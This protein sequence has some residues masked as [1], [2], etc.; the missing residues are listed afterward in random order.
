MTEKQ[1][2]MAV[3]GKSVRAEIRHFQMPD[4]LGGKLRVWRFLIARRFIQVSILVLFMGTLHYGWTLFNQLVLTGNMSSSR[5]FG[6][7]P[8]SDPFAVLQVIA[9]LQWPH[10]DALIGAAIVLAVYLLLGGRVFCAWACPVNMVA[11]L[12][13]WLREKWGIRSMFI[14]PSKTRYWALL[15]TLIL[16]FI[17][18]VAAF[19]WVSPI[20]IMH[21]ELIYGIGL[22]FIAVL[23]IFIFDLLVMARGWCGHFCPLGAFWSV[24]G[25]TAQIRV[26]F[27]D[28]SCTRCGDCVK[29]CPE[30]SVLSFKEAAQH[31]MVRSGECTNCGKCIVV[32][33]ENSLSFNLR[34]CIRSN[35]AL[36]SEHGSTS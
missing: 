31:G 25:R 2:D 34:A 11:D 23:G 18:G 8:L 26:A 20:A 10:M 28:A 5:L 7:I 19:E 29:E 30:P 22:G 16:S 35:S 24:V 17:L 15:L 4:T 3:P 36:R 21:R 13:N 33:P 27:D 32:C 6:V 12:A 9:S 14:V 1:K